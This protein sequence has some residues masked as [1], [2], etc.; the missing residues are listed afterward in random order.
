MK[1]KV[2]LLI[3]TPY[4]FL[5]SSL[6]LLGNISFVVDYSAEGASEGFNDPTLGASRRAAFAYSLS[7]WESYLVES[8]VGETITV[9][10]TFDPLGGSSNSATLGSA[11]ANSGA[12]ISGNTF[13]G[14]PLASHINGYNTNGSAHDIEITFNSDVDNQSVL[15]PKDFYYGID[16]NPGSDSD[17]VTT[18]L[19]EI[20]HGL[21]FN[22]DISSDG[23]L[24]NPTF[25]KIYDQF[26][27]D[28]ATGG[29]ALSS[30]TDAERAAAITSGS[31]YWS[32]INATAA[33]T[34]DRVHMFAPDPYDTGSSVSHVDETTHGELTLSPSQ[35][36]NIINHEISAIELGILEDMG[37]SIASVPEP[38]TALCLTVGI[39][40]FGLRRRR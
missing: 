31:L 34:G 7:I 23:S 17:F 20:A 18:A 39:L 10:A 25:S 29:N 30:M 22:S 5:T 38:S 28:A 6:S 19:H 9:R 13:A 36:G 26:L 11:S 40:G 14:T 27:I 12:I 2:S 3:F 32:G 24:R 37:W 8:Y 33:N 15:G 16:A 4:L 21:D 1:V 35:N